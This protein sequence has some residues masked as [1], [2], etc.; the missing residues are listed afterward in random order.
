MDYIANLDTFEKL[1]YRGLRICVNINVDDHTSKLDLLTLCQITTLELRYNCH[2]LLFM[3]KQSL[4]DSL[5]KNKTKNTRMHDAPVFN[6][7]K[8][9]IENVRGNVIYRG[10]IK[11]NALSPDDLKVTQ[12]AA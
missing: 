9:N 10:A 2:L 1:F 11:L 4:N 3:H 6:T 12:H 8:P 7:Y 5:L